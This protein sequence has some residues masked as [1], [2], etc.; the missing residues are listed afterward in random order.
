M[1][2]ILPYLQFYS[3]KTK[4]GE[5]NFVVTLFFQL[6]ND[7][8]SLHLPPVFWNKVMKP[9]KEYRIPF[10]GLKPGQHEYEFEV[11]DAF[12]E[13]F[14]NSEIDHADIKV[15]IMLE[16]QIN[17]MV[18]HFKLSGEVLSSWDRCGGEL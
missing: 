5:L 16:K 12:F 1:T 17:M 6:E 11:T 14:E 9:L 18:L 7:E 15:D 10:L 2:S 4:N 3:N 13:E 8:N